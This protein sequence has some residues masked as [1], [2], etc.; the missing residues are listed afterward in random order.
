MLRMFLYYMLYIDVLKRKKIVPIENNFKKKSFH[1]K[2]KFELYCICIRIIVQK[3]SFASL[4]NSSFQLWSFFP[5]VFYSFRKYN[6]IFKCLNKNFYSAPS[7]LHRYLRICMKCIKVFSFYYPWRKSEFCIF[8][9]KNF[10][11]ILLVVLEK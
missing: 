6:Q 11:K 4:E 8:R 9:S 10:R 2:S 3:A 5:K 7:L 1:F